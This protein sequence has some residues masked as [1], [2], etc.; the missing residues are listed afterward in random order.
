MDD[1][2]SFLE[3]IS[4]FQADL[5]LLPAAVLM[6]IVGG[7]VLLYKK[8]AWLGLPLYLAAILVEVMATLGR[9]FSS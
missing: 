2:R 3:P 8:G 1:I 9:I 6:F 7:A 5:V 4:T